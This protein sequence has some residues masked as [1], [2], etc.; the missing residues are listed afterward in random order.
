M[1]DQCNVVA[2]GGKLGEVYNVG[3]H[4]ERGV[5]ISEEW[6]I[7]YLRATAQKLFGKVKR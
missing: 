6:G 7:S 2:D 5:G 4:N 1:E 3:G